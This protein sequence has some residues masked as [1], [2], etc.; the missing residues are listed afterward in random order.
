MNDKKS[1]MILIYMVVYECM[2]N[3]LISSPIDHMSVVPPNMNV[4]VYNVRHVCSVLY[5]LFEQWVTFNVSLD[6]KSTDRP[7]PRLS[8]D[9]IDKDSDTPMRFVSDARDKVD[10]SSKLYVFSDCIPF[11]HLIDVQN[12]FVSEDYTLLENIRDSILT[13]IYNTFYI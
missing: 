7:I 9:A 11:E 2:I 8:H 6:K 4:L 12:F 5:I 1:K 3:R 13:R 10:W